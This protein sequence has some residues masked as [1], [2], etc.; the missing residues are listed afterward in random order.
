MEIFHDCV[1]IFVGL[2][3]VLVLLALSSL[4]SNFCVSALDSLG[5]T[6]SGA[7]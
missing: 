2:Y 6:D 5:R 7:I 1:S 3:T 4:L